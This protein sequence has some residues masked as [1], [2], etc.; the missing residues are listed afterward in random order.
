MTWRGLN[1]L[2]V[3]P[4]RGGSKGIP[5]KNLRR[6]A[7]ASLVAHAAA[8]AAALDWLDAAV[9]TTDDAEIA[10]EGARHGLAVPFLR[11]AD[12]ASD[13]AT[14]VAA[15]RH[16]WLASEA[17]FGR[18]FDCSVLLQPTSPLRQP[19]DV[20]RTIEAM[21][22]GG[23]AAAATVSPVPGHYLPEKML[24]MRDG[25]L[26]FLHPEGARYSNRQSAPPCYIRNGLCYGAMRAS[27]VDR[28]EIVERDCVGVVNDDFV[29]NIDEPIDLAIAEMLA[30]S[31]AGRS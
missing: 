1:V 18:R 29:V 16:T 3:V 19:G 6:V 20:E 13:V 11:P 24:V 21:L 2:A 31:G 28:G 25:I 5:R 7:G 30:G 15:W 8:T 14:G 9:L 22:A 17:H 23:H 26:S 27:V 10:K 4:A 12:L